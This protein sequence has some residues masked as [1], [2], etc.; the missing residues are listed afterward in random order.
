MYN[1][2]LKPLTVSLGN[3]FLDPNNPRLWDER[4]STMTNDSR[5]PE[6]KT[7]NRLQEVIE[8]MDIEELCFSI[9]RNGF[10]PLDSIVVRAIQGHGDKYVVVEGNRRL[11]ALRMLHRRIDDETA[12]AE[13]NISEEY[14]SNLK[15]ATSNI[16]VLLY[17]GSSGEDIAWMLQG[18]R[19]ISGIRPWDA[20]QRARLVA[21]QR[22]EEEKSFTQI[23]Q[24]FGLSAI[25]VGRLYRGYKGLQQMQKDD[26]Y[27]RKAGNQYFTLFEQA[28]SRSKVREWLGWNETTNNYTNFSN[29]QRFYSWITEDEEHSEKKRRIHNPKHIAII[30]QL[31][32][33]D[34]FDLIGEFER[35]ELDGGI[36]EAKTLLAGSSNTTNWRKEVDTARRCVSKITSGDFLEHGEEIQ[37]ELTKLLELV[38][39][40]I[41]VCDSYLSSDT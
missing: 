25:A 36:E 24:S 11:A 41:K 26:E 29:L 4:T 6:E 37:K 31:L 18:I 5:I 40:N 22:D 3:L 1:D 9:L 21:Q 28:Y 30:A 16:E 7:Q 33:H 35:Y 19:H 17:T 34:R 23:G 2:E 32:E 20:A 27:G 38:Q 12:E 39:R 8:K 15:Q 13:E 14:V 10:L